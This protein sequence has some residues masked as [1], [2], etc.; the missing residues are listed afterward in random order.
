MFDGV[1]AVGHPS[2]EMAQ[3]LPD[4]SRNPLLEAL[5]IAQQPSVEPRS[6]VCNNAHMSKLSRRRQELENRKTA[7]RLPGLDILR[8]VAICL[9]IFHHT[10]VQDC[11][12][13]LSSLLRIA[14]RGGWVGVD[15][16]F[17]LSGFL[18]SGLLFREYK[19]TGTVRLGRFL[20]RRGWRIYPPFWVMI[21]FSILLFDCGL[22][23][24]FTRRGFLGEL[25]FLQNY[26]GGMWGPTWSLA[27]EEHFYFFLA[28]IVF[29]LFRTQKK[30]SA[31]IFAKLPVIFVALAGVCLLAR[32][33]GGF[34]I[35]KAPSLI[36]HQSHYRMDS[37]MFGV[38]ISWW[39]HLTA[40]EDLRAWIETRRGIL[41][42]TGALCYS[43]AFIWDVNSNADM[44]LAVFGEGLFYL[45]G[46]LLV[47]GMIGGNGCDFLLLNWLAKLGSYSYSVY[48][49]NGIVYQLIL[50]DLRRGMGSRWG[51]GLEFTTNF[52]LSWVIGIT[53][54]K[55]IEI[56]LLKLRDRFLP[57]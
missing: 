33:A 11:P 23:D 3:Q 46:G 53:A 5:I 48:L 15:V 24:G 12:G 36:V 7:D 31:N 14:S 10:R 37:L 18:V 25:L 6:P 41:I 54:A 26:V 27:V 45:G 30:P 9:V 38:L 50:V 28:G 49:W 17:V 29:F 19:R 56:P 57:A 39:W 40:K 1:G 4:K 42:I 32:V 52:A 35:H 2:G 34:L 20:L 22:W 51:N 43:P 44:S 8:F 13:V 47:L 16:F 55:A 21:L